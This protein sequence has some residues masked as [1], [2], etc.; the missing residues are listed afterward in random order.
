[1]HEAIHY[2]L[3]PEGVE[4]RR[5]VGI[6]TSRFPP[7]STHSHS[8]TGTHIL[9][10]DTGMRTGTHKGMH[11]RKSTGTRRLTHRHRRT[12]KHTLSFSVHSLIH[13]C[14]Q[15][16]VQTSTLMFVCLSSHRDAMA[17]FVFYP[18]AASRRACVF[19]Q[20]CWDFH[21]GSETMSVLVIKQ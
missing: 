6:Y 18:S 11:G 3:S 15:P 10:T 13:S 17:V 7:A 2:T 12:H 9:Y 14:N 21:R 20:V 5:D 16:I 19:D 4:W 1:M 8:R